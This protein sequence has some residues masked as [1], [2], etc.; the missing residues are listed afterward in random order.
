MYVKLTPYHRSW[1]KLENPKR[2]AVCVRARVCVCLRVGVYSMKSILLHMLTRHNFEAH[3]QTETT[4]QKMVFHMIISQPVAFCF[5]RLCCCFCRFSPF[6]ERVV[7]A[8]RR[9]A[10]RKRAHKPTPAHVRPTVARKNYF[11]HINLMGIWIWVERLTINWG[12]HSS[13]PGEP[14]RQTVS[15]DRCRRQ[16]WRRCSHT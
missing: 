14:P 4:T 2:L 5:F 11:P 16:R 1:E 7:D 12:S 6:C 10:I 8:D 9:Q 13:R 15:S 3:R